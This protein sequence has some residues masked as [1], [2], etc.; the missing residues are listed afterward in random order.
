MTTPIPVQFYEIVN[1]DSNLSIAPQNPNDGSALIQGPSG[2]PI[3]PQ[4]LWG[5]VLEGTGIYRVFNFLTG[6]CVDA[7]GENPPY[8]GEP[9]QQYHW[10]PDINNQLWLFDGSVF[11]SSDAQD[12]VWDVRG[13]T[14]PGT[15]IVLAT[16]GTTSSQ[17]WKAIPQS[18]EVMAAAR[19]RGAS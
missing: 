19:G 6:Y 14:Q 1:A 3:Q 2:N 18:A 4:F 15:A 13:S 5:F 10:K 7:G 17:N 12:L 9:L 11:T 16:R 8:N